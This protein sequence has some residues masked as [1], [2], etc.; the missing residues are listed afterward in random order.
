MYT[1]NPELADIMGEIGANSEISEKIQNRLLA[2]V[3]W[4]YL[5]ILKKENWR[6]AQC[7]LKE[8]LLPEKIKCIT[9]C[10]VEKLYSSATLH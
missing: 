6:I 1:L 9:G 8:G 5:N 10:D 4:A 3:D 7:L 2:I